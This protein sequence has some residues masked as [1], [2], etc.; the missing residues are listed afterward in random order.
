MNRRTVLTAGG[1][2]LLGSTA[3]GTAQAGWSWWGDS[4]DGSDGSGGDPGDGTEQPD[5]VDFA[6]TV[7][8]REDLALRADRGSVGRGDRITFEIE[9]T[10]ESEAALGCDVPWALQVRRNGEWHHVTWTEGRFHNLCYTALPPGGTTTE[11]VTMSAVAFSFDLVTADLAV[12]LTPGTYR[13]VLI[14]TNPFLAERFEY[15]G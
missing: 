14:G 12:D 7:F 4:S 3:A 5:Y 15:T 9:N 1:L 8:E 6:P 2:A 13:F 10:G 11:T